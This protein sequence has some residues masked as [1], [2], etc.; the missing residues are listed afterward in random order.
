METGLYRRKRR[1]LASSDVDGVLPVYVAG[2][3][4]LPSD[5]AR[6]RLYPQAR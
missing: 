6:Q 4:G 2:C 5:T 3:R 1:Q